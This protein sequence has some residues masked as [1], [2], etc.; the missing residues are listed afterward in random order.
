MKI[1]IALENTI[2]HLSQ[3]QGVGE[4]TAFR[5]A[6]QMC[7]WSEQEI[8]HFSESIKNIASLNTCFEC[9]I[10]SDD[11]LC[12]HCSDE[13]RIAS[14][15]IC[16]VE[17]LTDLLAIEKSNQFK[18]VFHILGGVLNPLAGI[19]PEEL[20][21]DSL[22]DRIKKHKYNE[23]ILAINPSIEG[24]AT[25]GYLK[26]LVPDFVSIKRIGFGVPIGGNLEYL[27]PL[28]I[29]KAFENKSIF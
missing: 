22:I 17:K 20:R 15:Q 27:D 12:K 28:T 2:K 25:C 3:L 21:L 6:L 23:I 11:G 10:F 19:G 14:G 16:V 26:S 29:L 5:Y 18:G 13:L 24:E 1:P 4:R 7:K 8:H 9:G